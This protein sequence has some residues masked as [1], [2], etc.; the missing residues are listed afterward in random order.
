[1]PELSNALRV[2]TGSTA[3]IREANISASEKESQ[4]LNNAFII[5]AVTTVLR[6]VPTTA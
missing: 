4:E 5:K 1:M 3:D 6:M 2:E